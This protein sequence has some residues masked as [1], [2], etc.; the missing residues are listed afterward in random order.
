MKVADAQPRYMA[1]ISPSVSFTI[2][3]SPLFEVS[4][5]RKRQNKRAKLIEGYTM[6]KL[7]DYGFIAFNGK[8]WADFQV[9]S[10]NAIQKTI[11]GFISAG[12]PVPDYLINGS[13]NLFSSYSGV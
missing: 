13:H 11:N 10:Y 6:R 4:K 7:L 1:G 8:T 12:L 2:N 3:C 9:D 5:R